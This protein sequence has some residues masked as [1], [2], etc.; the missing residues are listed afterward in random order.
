MIKMSKTKKEKIHRELLKK[1][2]YI[3]SLIILIPAE[4][5]VI[6]TDK[7][8]INLTTKIFSILIM[9]IITIATPYIVIHI[10]FEIEERRGEK[11]NEKE[12]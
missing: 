12:K 5:Y 3:A 2:T 8:P 4:I 6:I 9:I 11:Q 10:A 1:A 7:T